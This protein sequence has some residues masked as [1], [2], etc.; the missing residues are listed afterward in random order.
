[1]L[2]YPLCSDEPHASWN[3]EN[4]GG[5]AEVCPP[6]RPHG[7]VLGAEEQ[8]ASKC[9]SQGKEQ[10]ATAGGW[11]VLPEGGREDRALG[12]ASVCSQDPAGLEARGR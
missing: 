7:T 1:M 8:A 9:E 2:Y 3:V 5:K 12:P 10:S 6:R 11:A 4:E